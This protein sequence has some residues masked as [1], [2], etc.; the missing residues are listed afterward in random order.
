MIHKIKILHGV[1]RFS[2]IITDWY[3]IKKILFT[4]LINQNIFSLNYV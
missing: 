1:N 3:M 2:Y 4:F